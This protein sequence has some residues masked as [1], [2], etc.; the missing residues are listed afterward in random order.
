MASEYE[1]DV[2]EGGKMSHLEFVQVKE[3]DECDD[4]HLGCDPDCQ[5]M[6][7]VF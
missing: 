1:G 6:Q 7:L 2:C 3:D 5:Y 4:W